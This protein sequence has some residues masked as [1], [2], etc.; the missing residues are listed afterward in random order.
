MGICGD[1]DLQVRQ[2]E[3]QPRIIYLGQGGQVIQFCEEDIQKLY[4][5]LKTATDLKLDHERDGWLRG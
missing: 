5:F 3:D 1:L 2:Y 4:E